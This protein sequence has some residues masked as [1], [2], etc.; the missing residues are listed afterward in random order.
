MC[1]FFI[2]YNALFIFL[3]LYVYNIFKFTGFI[4]LFFSGLKPCDIVMHVRM[5]ILSPSVNIAFYKMGIIIKGLDVHHSVRQWKLN[6]F[7]G[8]L[9]RTFKR[10]HFMR[11]RYI[12]STTRKFQTPPK[13]GKK[14]DP[15][16]KCLD[17]PFLEYNAEAVIQSP[18][19]RQTGKLFCSCGW[20]RQKYPNFVVK[21]RP[22]I[23]CCVTASPAASQRIKRGT[24][25]G[26]G[27]EPKHFLLSLLYP[28]PLNVY[29]FFS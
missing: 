3:G 13:K 11:T 2:Y 12:N 5:K 8:W 16:K 10:Q 15:F 17:A 26:Y 28:P 9:R 24:A 14:G 19:P 23:S 4:P 27:S 29:F 6:F 7:S 21:T 25:P 22:R 18:L 20:R 1:H